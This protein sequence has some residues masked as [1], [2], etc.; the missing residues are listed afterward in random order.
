MPR[1]SRKAKAGFLNTRATAELVAMAEPED[2]RTPPPIEKFPLIVF[3]KLGAA[4]GV[5]A[6]RSVS[7][8][9]GHAVEPHAGGIQHEANVLIDLAC[10]DFCV[11]G[12]AGAP[13]GFP[14]GAL[15]F[16]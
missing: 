8:V 13:S 9:S 4:A 16:I 7:S 1:R 11:R 12:L 15:R 10:G 6:S 2:A 14:E 5:V 3:R